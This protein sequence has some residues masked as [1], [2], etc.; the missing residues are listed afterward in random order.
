MNLFWTLVTIAASAVLLGWILITSYNY[1]TSFADR[2]HGFRS[3]PEASEGAVP[4]IA[5]K[6]DQPDVTHSVP[7]AEIKRGCFQQD[8]IR[9]VDEPVFVEPSNIAAR[10]PDD[11]LGIALSYK[12][13]HRFYPFPMLETRELVNDTVAGDP[14]LVSY[15]PLCGTGIVFERTVAGEEVAFGVSGLLWQ[16]NLLMYDRA[17]E[18]ADRNL[19]SQVRAEAVVGPRTGTSLVVVPSDIMRFRDWVNAFPEGVVLDTGL[20]RD[21]YSGQYYDVAQRFE[22]NFN[23]NTS[24]LP[25]MTPVYGII[26]DGSAKAYPAERL[27][28]GTTFDDFNGRTILISRSPEGLVTLTDNASGATVPD[29]E[30]F[31]FSWSAA[32]PETELYEPGILTP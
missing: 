11:S 19:W 24:P 15:C 26:L 1:N 4:D 25:P 28:I 3:L 6:L 31:W 20:P 29:I 9:S 13:E 21:P 8:C 14:I 5:T 2:D 16:S 17:D 30:G 32:Y 12:G 18:F 23:L 22:P 7:L 27:P 10:V